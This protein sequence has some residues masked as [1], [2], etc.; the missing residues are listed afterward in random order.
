MGIPK[1][2]SRVVNVDGRSYRFIVKETHIPDHKDQKELSITVQEDVK[3]PGRVFQFRAGYAVI[4]T[5]RL[6]QA[7]I[8]KAIEAGWKPGVRGAAFKMGWEDK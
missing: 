7:M 8:V 5:P 1:K 2:K 6:V 4:I 3:K